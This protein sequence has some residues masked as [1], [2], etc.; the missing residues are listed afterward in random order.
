MR[1]TLD[2]TRYVAIGARN[3]GR[4]LLRVLLQKGIQRPLRERLPHLKREFFER[5]D[6]R[7]RLQGFGLTRSPS[8]NFS[9]GLGQFE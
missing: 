6:V 7:V 9:P 1:H 5:R 4:N 2:R 3:L 8:D